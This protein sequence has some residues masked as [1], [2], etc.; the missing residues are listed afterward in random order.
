MR[1][2]GLKSEG[3]E[4]AEQKPEVT[5]RAGVWIEIS[6]ITP[7]PAVRRSL[8]VRE[9]GLK[10]ITYPLSLCLRLVT[11][12]AGVWIEILRHPEE[13]MAV[14]VTPRAGVWIEISSRGG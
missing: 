8:P 7:M 14:R 1:E 13:W 4:A 5:P 6:V 12:R 11:P 10:S 9:C 2:C 3:Q